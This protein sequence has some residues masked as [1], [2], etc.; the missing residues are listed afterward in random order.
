MNMV[1]DRPKFTLPKESNP[2]LN[3]VTWSAL[4]NLK[5]A[6]VPKCIQIFMQEKAAY[7]ADK[8]WAYATKNYASPQSTQ[9][10]INSKSDEQTMLKLLNSNPSFRSKVNECIVQA[11]FAILGYAKP[12]KSLA[13][14]YAHNGQNQDIPN[15]QAGTFDLIKVDR[16]WDPNC[17][18]AWSIEVKTSNKEGRP[19][20]LHRA[21][22]VLLHIL[23][24]DQVQVFASPLPRKERNDD[25]YLSLGILEGVSGWTNIHVDNS[26]AITSW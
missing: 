21:D 16:S 7:Y 12:I 3:E 24:K 22:I 10:E 17:E 6:Y 8:P 14:T 5:Y 4:A 18:T 11:P 23:G 1:I 15:H 19:S 25:T 26:W 9:I 20:S 2:T 13:S